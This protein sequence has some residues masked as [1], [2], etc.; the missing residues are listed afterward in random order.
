[1]GNGLEKKAEA[2]LSEALRDTGAVDPRPV[3]RELLR[4]LRGHGQ[5][6]YDDAIS[7]YQNSVVA[8]IG[9]EKADPLETWLLYACELAERIRP[10]RD[11][12]IDG[13]GR[14][15]PLEL[16]PSWRDLILH[17]P[18]DSRSPCL[19]VGHPPELTRAQ[20]ATVAVLVSRKVSRPAI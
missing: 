20:R 18:R 9:G 4:E 16:P 15:T 5:Q 6:P 19:V 1:M 2:R 13:T 11:V 12:V 17:L 10:G 8:R 14:A 7:A 3:C